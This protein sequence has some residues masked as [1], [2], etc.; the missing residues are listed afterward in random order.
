VNNSDIK[1]LKNKWQTNTEAYKTSEIGSGV[2]SFVK[3]VFL[4]SEL[5][6]LT[7]SAHRTPKLGTFLQDRISKKRRTTGFHF[8]YRPRNLCLQN[9]FY[10]FTTPNNYE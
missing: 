3:D 2:Q 8:V 7:E 5:F 6:N 1:Q 4:S 10:N 9:E